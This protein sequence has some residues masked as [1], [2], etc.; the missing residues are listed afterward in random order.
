[1]LIKTLLEQIR[2]ILKNDGIE[3]FEFES[4][5]ILEDVFKLNIYDMISKKVECDDLDE[6]V[7]QCNNMAN[8]RIEGFPLQYILG[9]W[10]FYGLSFKV[11]EGVLIP[12]QDTETLVDYVL[13]MYKN[14]VGLK[15][16]DL[17]SGSGCIPIS[18][19][20][21]LTNAEVHAIELSKLAYPYLEENIT[22]NSSK[23]I[24][25]LGDVLEPSTAEEFTGFNIITAN[26]PY[27]TKNDMEHLQKEVSFEPKTSLFGGD[28]GLN[29]YRTI[30]K[31]WKNS[32]KVGGMLVF[33]VGQGQ[34]EDVSKIMLENGFSNVAVIPDLCG[35]NR[36]VSGI[37]L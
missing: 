35:I 21:H 2:T 37:A 30:C 22:L 14:D 11:G 18:L 34:D 32:L 8:R 9:K 28:D 19:E 16:L 6:K 20:K 31:V 33:E 13:T 23:V 27:L 15:V 17:C 4:V 25:H 5:Y 12:R 3:N 26:P 10:E 29:Y 1:M 7:I 36:V 24:A